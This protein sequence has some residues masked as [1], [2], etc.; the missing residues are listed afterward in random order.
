MNAWTVYQTEVSSKEENK[1]GRETRKAE[2]RD[3]FYSK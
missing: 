2:G 1:A 3:G